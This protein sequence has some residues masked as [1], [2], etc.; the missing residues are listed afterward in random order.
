MAEY[1][2]KNKMELELRTRDRFHFRWVPGYNVR[3]CANCARRSPQIHHRLQRESKWN[4]TIP[5]DRS[6]REVLP[7]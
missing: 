4:G 7:L 6:P 1:T 5:R 2:R 3:S